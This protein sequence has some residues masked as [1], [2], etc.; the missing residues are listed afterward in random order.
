[1][2]KDREIPKIDGLTS[3]EVRE[4]F[5]YLE[6]LRD[7]GEINMFGARPYLMD[8]FSMYDEELAKKV[9]MT[10]MGYV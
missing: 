2:I 8:E 7:S 6:E 10:W 5:E 3:F 9:L 4:M 1:M